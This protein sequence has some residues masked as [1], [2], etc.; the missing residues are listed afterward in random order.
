MSGINE[1]VVLRDPQ[2]LLYRQ[3]HP[4]FV[5]EGRVSS[6]VFRPTPKD[7]HKLSVDRGSLTTAESSFDRFIGRGSGRSDGVMGVTVE[8]CSRYDLKVYADPIAPTETDE[9]NLSH[10]LIDF[11]TI[12]SENQREKRAKKLARCARNRNW[13]YGPLGDA[14]L[15]K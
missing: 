7:E 10:A 3:V 12:S 11:T 6:Q 15:R 8:E 4:S 5:H 13:L 9:G 14:P 2:E 1:S